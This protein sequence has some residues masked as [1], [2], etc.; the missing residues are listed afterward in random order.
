MS[1]SVGF[2]V[3]PIEVN[4]IRPIIALFTG[5]INIKAKR[6]QSYSRETGV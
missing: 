2:V 6:N 5:V 4:V 3:F 1:A